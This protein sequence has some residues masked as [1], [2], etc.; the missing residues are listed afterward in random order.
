M[1][2]PE[3]TTIRYTT[4][5]STGWR[6][7]LRLLTLRPTQGPSYE[8]EAEIRPATPWIPSPPDNDSETTSFSYD[9]KP[10]GPIRKINP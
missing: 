10:I 8:F 2:E 3:T 5:R 7:I 4:F 9:L 1:T 6:R